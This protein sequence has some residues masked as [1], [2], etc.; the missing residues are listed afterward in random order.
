MSMKCQ[1][2]NILEDGLLEGE[3]TFRLHLSTID[4]AIFLLEPTTIDVIIFNNDGKL[5][6]EAVLSE[7]FIEPLI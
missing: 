6:I 7:S 3:E 4:T 5:T 1:I 2:I